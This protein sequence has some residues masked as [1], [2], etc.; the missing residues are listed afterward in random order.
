[1]GLCD[2]NRCVYFYPLTSERGPRFVSK[3]S[4]GI[5]GPFGFL[6]PIRPWRPVVEDGEGIGGKEQLSAPW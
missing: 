5:G 6:M 2:N 1:M 3:A 4:R